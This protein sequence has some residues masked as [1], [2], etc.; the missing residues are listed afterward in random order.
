M[1]EA[2]ANSAIAFYFQPAMTARRSLPATP[3]LQPAWST[4]FLVFVNDIDPSMPS[5]APV[6]QAINP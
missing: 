2:Q 1:K 4:V 5:T 6:S 3:S